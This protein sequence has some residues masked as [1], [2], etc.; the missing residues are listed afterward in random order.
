MCSTFGLNCIR[1]RRPRYAHSADVDELADRSM[2]PRTRYVGVQADAN[3]A[4]LELRS[5]LIGQLGLHRGL[6][7]EEP[8]TLADGRPDAARSQIGHARGLA[9]SPALRG[10]C[11]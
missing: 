6:R 2:A 11:C 1:S 7:S 5:H 10:A 8:M 3:R 9:C 4:S